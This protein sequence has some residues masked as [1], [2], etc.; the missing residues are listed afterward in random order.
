MRDLQ[1]AGIETLEDTTVRE[2]L[3]EVLEQPLADAGLDAEYVVLAF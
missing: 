1:A 3:H 2:Q